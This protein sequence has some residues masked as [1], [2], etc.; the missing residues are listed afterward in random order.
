MSLSRVKHV[1]KYLL[2]HINMYFFYNTRVKVREWTLLLALW[3][4]SLWHIT[5]L[6]SNINHLIYK[7]KKADKSDGH[8]V[9]HVIM[10]KREAYIRFFWANISL[11]SCCCFVHGICIN[12]VVKSGFLHGFYLYKL[13]KITKILISYRRF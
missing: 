7:K 3:F 12:I 9:F 5:N 2:K 6:L 11:S 1:N 8:V 10:K 4:H 13:L